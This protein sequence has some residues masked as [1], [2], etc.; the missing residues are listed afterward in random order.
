VV[1][2]EPTRRALELGQVD[3]LII[4]ADP[5]AIT[6][7][8]GAERGATSSDRSSSERAGDQLIAMARQTSARL[9][10]IEDASLLAPAG[11]VGATLRFKV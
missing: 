3:E 6:P 10:F 2:V 9:R 7:T 8:T 1:G 11:G 4:A 5:G